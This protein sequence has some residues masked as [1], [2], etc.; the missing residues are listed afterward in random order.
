MLRSLVV[1][2][3]LAAASASHRVHGNWEH[4]DDF[5]A[6]ADEVLVMGGGGSLD[7]HE[8]VIAVEQQM[9]EQLSALTLAVSDPENAAYGKHLTYDQVHTMTANPEATRAVKAWC[10]AQG[11]GMVVVSASSHG[12]YVTVR[13]PR[14]TWDRVLGSALRKMV[15]VETGHAVFRSRSFTMPA[16]LRGHA[17]HVFNVVELPARAGPAQRV[18]YLEGAAK[19]RALAE[20]ALEAAGGAQVGAYPCHSVMKMA[21]FNYRYNMTTNDATGQSQ[22]VFGQKGAY[23]RMRGRRGRGERG[24]GERRG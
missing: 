13:A 10:A 21:C 1:L 2:L 6:A 12:E 19:E 8:V 16:G 24:E 14:A 11:A 3:S 7:I 15:H 9:L 23:V 18:N 22:M 5:V 20:R 4:R 17:S